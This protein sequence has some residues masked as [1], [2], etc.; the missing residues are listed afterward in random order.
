MSNVWQALFRKRKEQELAVKLEGEQR[1]RDELQG[2]ISDLQTQVH[3]AVE[4]PINIILRT[5]NDLART[6]TLTPEVREALTAVV[7]SLNSSNL[8]RPVMQQ[9]MKV[10]APVD[11]TT[12]KWLES[13]CSALR[14]CRVRCVFSRCV[15]RCC[16]WKLATKTVMCTMWTRRLL[17]FRS[18]RCQ[19]MS[20]R[21][22]C[23]A[24]IS[25]SGT[26]R[27]INCLLCYTTCLQTSGF[28]CV[29]SVLSFSTTAHF[30]QE[31]FS[32]SDSKLRAFLVCV[33]NH[34]HSNNPYHNFRHAFDVTQGVYH[35][36]T[37]GRAAELLTPLDIFALL[38]SALCH[39][40]DHP[41]TNNVFH[42]STCS[43]LAL[44][45]NDKSILENHHAAYCFRLMRLKENDVA[46]GLTPAHFRE[47]RQMVIANILATDLASHMEFSGKCQVLVEKGYAKTNRD[48]RIL[49]TQLLLK[50]A[51]VS[52]PCKNFSL[53]KAWSNLVLEEFFQQGDQEK[54]L[55]LPVSPYMD[56]SAKAQGRMSINFIDFIVAPYYTKLS[57]LLP[58]ISPILDHVQINRNEWL[59]VMAEEEALARAQMA[60]VSSPVAPMPSVA[61][62]ASSA[63]AK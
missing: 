33:R 23:G 48:D 21:K 35:F 25:I 52:N 60:T 29:H 9:K 8:Y 41:G 59:K 27:K 34:Y 20:N 61:P 11:E 6:A 58:D 32:I 12:R 28:R 57:H 55:Q 16:Q 7:K 38:I 53:A 24:G 42:A 31:R 1:T 5:V 14:R 22:V 62:A 50:A 18:L 10:S 26:T 15:I 4:T 30:V 56:R 17:R 49:L 2:Q 3:E 43:K 54:A 36:L 63:D 45:Y 44:R 39:D 40:L 51:D 46:E 13:V 19:A 37:V 47:F